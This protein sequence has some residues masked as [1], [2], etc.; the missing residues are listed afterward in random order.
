MD[1]KKL[2][3][4]YI[5][6]PNELFFK[7]RIL[8][9]NT[10]RRIDFVQVETC[11]RC[12]LNCLA[13]DT[14]RRKNKKAFMNLETFS[15]IISNFP[16]LKKVDLVGVGEPL[17]NPYLPSIIKFASQKRIKTE[18]YSNGT[19]FIKNLKPC[20]RAG[21][22]FLNISIDAANPKMFA[23]YR[24]GAKLNEVIRNVRY[25]VKLIKR[26]KSKTIVSFN[27]VVS[28]ENWREIPNIIKLASM[29]GISIITT[30]PIHHWGGA[31][32]DNSNNSFFG[33]N[34]NHAISIAL[35]AAKMSEKHGITL[36]M[37]A[38]DRIGE[39]RNFKNYYCPWLW[40]TSSIKINGDV[41]TCTLTEDKKM[42]FGNIFKAPFKKIWNNKNYN[43]FR[44]SFLK[45]QR[46]IVCKNCQILL[47]WGLHKS[48][49]SKL[50]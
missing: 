49:L 3:N 45:N 16:Y 29:L 8:P 14:K 20:I 5:F 37:P 19:L 18:I 39:E 34:K 11:A 50:L 12:N 7:N 2:I 27:C 35:K 47:G 46:H 9:G 28:R 33:I 32:L 26:M 13:C 1:K 24:K 43:E 23:K 30:D 31:R 25:A 10:K 42:I 36:Y 22:S 6:D 4:K 15:T 21:L 17:L 48:K 40:N 44:K 41:A 38:L